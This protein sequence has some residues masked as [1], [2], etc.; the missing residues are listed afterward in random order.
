MFRVI[1]LAGG[2]GTRL[3]PLSRE[4]LPKQFLCLTSQNY[5]MFQLTINR[6]LLLNPDSIMIIC[7]QSH[8]NLV[9]KQIGELSIET[10]CHIQ[11]VVEP[12][13]RNTAPAIAVACLLGQPDDRLLVLPSDHYFVDSIFADSIKIGLDCLGSMIVFLGIKPIR[14]ETGYGYLLTSEEVC[15]QVWKLVGFIEK[16]TTEKA[17]EYLTDGSYW[18]NAGI[19]LFQI[20]YMLT[21]FTRHC[22][23]ILQGVRMTLESS[24]VESSQLTEPAVIWLKSEYYSQVRDQSIDYAIMEHQQNGRVVIYND[25]WSD[26]GSFQALYD[27]C[28]SDQNGNVI[29]DGGNQIMSI[30]CH[31]CLIKSED[32]LVTVMDLSNLLVIQQK[33]ALLIGDLH[34]SQ[35]V[36]LVV[37]NLKKENRPEIINPLQQS[38]PWG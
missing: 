9:I 31:N 15:H 7:H 20:Q 6:A 1:I 2:S 22:S 11:L 32:K 38:A 28:K 12:I 27:F 8:Y 21:E 34:Q 10:E 17:I 5:S 23:D 19:F 14:P 30:N 37:D 36:K 13:G 18:W 26:I 35:H 29:L 33:D 25:E 3:W 16:P 4:N 24:L